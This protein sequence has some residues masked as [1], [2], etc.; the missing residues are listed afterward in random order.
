[1]IQL[2][3][4]QYDQIPDITHSRFLDV[5]LECRGVRIPVKKYYTD[6]LREIITH[7]PNHKFNHI[8]QII[9]SI[10]QGENGGSS[11]IV[12]KLGTKLSWIGY[13]AK[14]CLMRI[15][16][17]IDLIDRNDALKI[18]MKIRLQDDETLFIV[19]NNNN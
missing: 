14:E 11:K 2:S 1:M 19:N 16:K 9:P 3:V 13:S 5:E 7:L 18:F 4:S 10:E 8:R 12:N 6:V 17:I 15:M